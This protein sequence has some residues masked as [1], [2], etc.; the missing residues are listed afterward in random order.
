MDA[1][2]GTTYRNISPIG[3][4]LGN[5]LSSERTGDLRRYR[6]HQPCLRKHTYNKRDPQA[7]SDTTSRFISQRS[8]I[9][10]CD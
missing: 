1:D 6:H 8:E 4:E 10:Q 7:D 9:E 5:P 3:I 2:R